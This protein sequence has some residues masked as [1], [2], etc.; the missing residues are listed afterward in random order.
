[1]P[2]HAR[3]R[4]VLFADRSRRKS[5]ISRAAAVFRQRTLKTIFLLAWCARVAC[6]CALRAH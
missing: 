5:T 1:M 4:R 3:A 6:M 2:A